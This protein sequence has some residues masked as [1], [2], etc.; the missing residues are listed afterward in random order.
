MAMAD[1]VHPTFV[2][3]PATGLPVL[4]TVGEVQ[5]RAMVERGQQIVQELTEQ[6]RMQAAVIERMRASFAVLLLEADG[7]FMEFDLREY[8]AIYGRE[9]DEQFL[10]TPDGRKLWRIFLKGER[11]DKALAEHGNG[12][13]SVKGGKA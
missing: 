12:L 5:T 7:E 10:E 6:V 2:R 4:T 11:A 1:A 8:E 3:D 9:L 13:R